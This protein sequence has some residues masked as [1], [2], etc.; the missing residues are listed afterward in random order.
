MGGYWHVLRI[1]KH[2]TR[3]PKLVDMQVLWEGSRDLSREPETRGIVRVVTGVIVIEDVLKFLSSG[4]IWMVCHCCR[5]LVSR[6]RRCRS[7]S[8]VFMGIA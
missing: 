2:E 3:R 8:E 7:G 6:C 4:W 1:V 5:W